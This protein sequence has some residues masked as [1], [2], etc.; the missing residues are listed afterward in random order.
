MVPRLAETVAAAPGDGDTVSA[1]E[2]FGGAGRRHREDV[3]ADRT[4]RINLSAISINTRAGRVTC[5]NYHNDGE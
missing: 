2:G 4:N 1:V 5:A 3:A